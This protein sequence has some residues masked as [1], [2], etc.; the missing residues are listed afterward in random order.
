MTGN[1]QTPLGTV[2]N[3]SPSMPGLASA[4]RFAD[5]WTTAMTS[6]KRRFA[7]RRNSRIFAIP[8]DP[9]WFFAVSFPHRSARGRPSKR[10]V[11]WEEIRSVDAGRFDPPGEDGRRAEEI[12][13]GAERAAEALAALP[14]VQREAIVLFDLEGLGLQEVARLQNVSLSAVKSRLNRGRERLRNHTKAGWAP[15]VPGPIA[16]RRRPAARPRTRGVALLGQ[17]RF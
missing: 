3:L 4:R 5:P 9:S 7:A 16:P 2:W 12:R 1:D 14:A 6:I 11:S 8:I 13:R 10:F 15:E 17:P